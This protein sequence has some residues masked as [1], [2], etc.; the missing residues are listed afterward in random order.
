MLNV[1]LYI[2]FIKNQKSDAKVLIFFVSLQ[3]QKEKSVTLTLF[4]DVVDEGIGVLM[5]LVGGVVFA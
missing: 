5:A 1:G 3:L 2:F 4:P